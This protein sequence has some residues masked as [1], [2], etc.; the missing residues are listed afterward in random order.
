L[1]ALKCWAE[2]VFIDR[3][4]L[5][6]TIGKDVISYGVGFTRTSESPSVIHQRYYQLIPPLLALHALILYLPRGIWKLFENGLMSKLLDKLSK[7]E[8][9]FE[10]IRKFLSMLRIF[11]NFQYEKP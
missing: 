10:K 1:I 11:D 8:M 4:L 5:N 7:F 3:E 9:N 2:G 6:G